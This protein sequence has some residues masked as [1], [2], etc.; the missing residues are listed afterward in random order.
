MGSLQPIIIDFGGGAFVKNGNYTD[1]EGQ[2]FISY[3]RFIGNLLLN[4][5]KTLFRDATL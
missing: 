3:C 2:K 5:A 1:F 4:N